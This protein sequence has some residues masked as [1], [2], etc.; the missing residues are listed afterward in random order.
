MYIH[1]HSSSGWLWYNFFTVYQFR[2]S[3]TWH[4]YST[5]SASKH[6]HTLGKSFNA[7]AKNVTIYISI[8]YFNSVIFCL[9][10]LE[11]WAK[12][13]DI[14]LWTKPGEESDN[15]MIEVI[16]S[17]LKFVYSWDLVA[18][19]NLPSMASFN[20]IVRICGLTYPD[21][22]SFLRSKNLKNGT[23]AIIND[24]TLKNLR[25]YQIQV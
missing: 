13:D 6:T 10:F 4:S 15:K 9:L 23:F 21:D 7:P 22:F 3:K 19:S 8:C 25:S 17:L 18:E 12:L 20:W 2:S 11:E 5:P 16:E 24:V 14:F 1:S